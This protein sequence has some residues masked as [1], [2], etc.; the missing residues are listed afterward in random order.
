LI[1][2][3]ECKNA[4]QAREAGFGFDLPSHTPPPPLLLQLPGCGLQKFRQ[5]ENRWVKSWKQMLKKE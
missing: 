2:E 3:V 4:Q 1:R 5:E